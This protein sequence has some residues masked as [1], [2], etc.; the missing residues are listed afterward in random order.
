MKRFR[1]SATQETDE[2]DVD[3][4]PL[5]DIV[6]ILL[7]FF[8][9]TTT[10]V[11]ESGMRV[12]KPKPAPSEPNDDE[13]IVLIVTEEGEVLHE[14]QAIGVRGVRPLVER[15]LRQ[16]DMP[17]VVQGVPS[18]TVG[19]GIRVMDEAKLAGAEEVSIAER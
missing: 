8:I 7:I 5:I 4:S 12:N 14:G 2:A 16:Q 15:K 18:A 6:F 10:F 11:E 3:I 1:N 19:R 13:S 17:V 9:V